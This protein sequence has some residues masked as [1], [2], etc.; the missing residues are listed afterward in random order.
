MPARPLRSDP[1]PIIAHDPAP[2]PAQMTANRRP[3]LL[4]TAARL[5]LPDY[6]RER[7]L[8]RLLRGVGGDVLSALETLESEAEQ[9]RRDGDGRWSCTR[10]VDLVIALL[11]ERQLRGL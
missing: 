10:H 1:Q 6:R 4:M 8:P 9:L 5:G 3:R 7:D 11:A 2:D